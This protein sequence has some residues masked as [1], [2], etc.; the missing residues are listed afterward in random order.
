MWRLTS[1]C[2]AARC[3]LRPWSNVSAV[4][5]FFFVALS[6]CLVARRKQTPKT[7][8]IPDAEP[9]D[10]SIAGQPE[11]DTFNALFDKHIAPHT[12]YYCLTKIARASYPNADGSQRSMIIKRCEPMGRWS[13]CGLRWNQ[14]IRLIQW[15]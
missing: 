9:D 4:F 14:T 2:S 15:R 5:G 8:S 13:S 11:S 7:L 1:S 6:I 10:E 3:R 12:N